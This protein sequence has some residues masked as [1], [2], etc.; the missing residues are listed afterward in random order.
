M[1]QPAG[2]KERMTVAPLL[3]MAGSSHLTTLAAPQPVSVYQAKKFSVETR[4]PGGETYQRD[5]TNL[6]GDVPLIVRIASPVK[7]GQPARVT[8]V[9]NS[10]QTKY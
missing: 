2:Q 3:S 10:G 5:L 9:N 8:V 6:G 7:P 1:L 4:D